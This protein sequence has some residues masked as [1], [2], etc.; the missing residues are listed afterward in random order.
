M[1]IAPTTP[2]KGD[3]TLNPQQRRSHPQYSTNAIASTIPSSRDRTLNPSQWRSHS[4]QLAKA[5]AML[6]RS[7]F[8]L[9]HSDRF[10]PND[11]RHRAANLTSTSNSLITTA[12]VHAI[13]MRLPGLQAHPLSCQLPVGFDSSMLSPSVV[14]SI[15]CFDYG[16]LS[17]ITLLL[18]SDSCCPF[19][20]SLIRCGLFS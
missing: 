13:V 2:N 18:S 5:I 9:Q 19:F 17:T 7:L 11:P 4:Q 12:P 20:S 3:R 6:G 10:H 15:F 8:S 1:A 14:G 16:A